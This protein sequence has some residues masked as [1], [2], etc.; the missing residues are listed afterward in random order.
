MVLTPFEQ[1]IIHLQKL[2]LNACDELG[3]LVMDESF[4]HWQLPKNP[5]DYHLYF[6]DW[7][8]KDME[9]MLLRDRNHPSIIIWSVGNEIKE[10]ADSSGVEI[11]KKLKAKVKEFDSERPVTQAVC[12]LWE[13]NNRPWDDNNAAFEY[14]D[15]HGYNYSYGRYK[16]DFENFPNRIMIGTE[17]FPLEAFENWKAVEENPFVIGDFVWTGMDYF[18]EAAIGN[19]QLES[20]KEEDYPGMPWFNAYCGDIS[21]LGYKKP[22]MF[23]PRCSLEK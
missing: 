7:W 12:S 23:L 21:I 6:D 22:Q 15:V 9:S 19:A 18:G 1:H 10:R 16:M 14:L 3:M 20:E 2:F 4:D 17:S 13:F 11:V 5:Q 8:E